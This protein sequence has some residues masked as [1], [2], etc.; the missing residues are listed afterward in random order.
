[1]NRLTVSIV[2]TTMNRP[3]SVLQA[4]HSVFAQ[5]YPYYDLHIVDDGS[6]DQT[7]EVIEKILAGRTN[8]FYW[9]HKKCRGLSAARNTG[10]VNSRAKFI[11]FLDDDD[12]LKPDSLEKRMAVVQ[13]LNPDDQKKLGVIYNGCEIHI[14]HEN[15]ITYNMPRIEGNIANFIREKGLSTIP[16][17]GLH[18]RT[19]LETIGGFDESLISSI[20][21]DLWMGLATHGFYAFP[22]Y[23]PLTITFNHIRRKSLVTDT[24]SRIMGV[25]QYLE[26]WRPVYESWYGV[27]G[28]KKYTKTYRT[29]VLGGL[30]AKKFVDREWHETRRL[31]KHVLYHNRHA[32]G[33]YIRLFL[34]FL[35][36]ILRKHTPARLITFVRGGKRY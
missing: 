33:E 8:A 14:P 12:E 3:Q 4:I 36:F 16:S 25:E 6:T 19:V 13:K 30:A 9:K 32:F 22:V 27:R 29:R 1:M 34:C 10:I 28:A 7:S 21:H 17:T 24:Q 15:R 20:D 26:K 5:T 35:R 11:V 18:P 2:I 23:E 31:L